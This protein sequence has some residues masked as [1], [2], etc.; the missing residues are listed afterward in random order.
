MARTARRSRDVCE[1]DVAAYGVFGLGVAEQEPELKS[2][3]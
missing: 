3:W 1:V 2:R